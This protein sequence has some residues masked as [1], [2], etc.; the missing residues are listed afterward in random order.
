MKR[1][2]VFTLLTLMVLAPLVLQ[3]QTTMFKFHQ[4][5]EFASL[6]QS[7]DVNNSFSLNVS[8][9]CQPYLH[10]LLVF[11]RLHHP[12]HHSDCWGYSQHGLH[13]PKHAASD[14]EF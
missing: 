7:T 1:Q 2:F 14:L 13:R 6:S 5:G 12:Y 3:A 11:L 4:D 8:R 9:Q 10:R